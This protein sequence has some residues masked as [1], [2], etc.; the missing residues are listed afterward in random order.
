[1]IDRGRKV[2]KEPVD[3]RGIRRI[4]GRSASGA[5]LASGTLQPLDI[6][7]RENDVGALHAR[8]TG[9]LEADAGAPT[10]DDD[11]LP[12]ELHQSWSANICACVFP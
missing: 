5:K 7:A 8:A 1:M 10:D 4:E 2:L 11:G 9:R 6:P 3:R 12:L